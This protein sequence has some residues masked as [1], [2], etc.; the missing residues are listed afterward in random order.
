[1][2][3]GALT[4]TITAGVQGRPFQATINGLS[5]GK[6]D[7]RSD[8]APGFGV[9]NGKVLNEAL[10]YP[11]STVVLREY[12][13]G[14]SP[15]FRDT[16]IEITAATR[17]EL[18]AQAAAAVPGYVSRR[19]VADRQ[20]NGDLIYTMKVTDALGAT[21]SYAVGQP[22]A[23]SITGT[24]TS[25]TVGDS[26]AFNPS[27]SGGT[28]PYTLSLFS[29]ALPAGRAIVGLSVTGTYTTAATYNYTLRVTDNLGATA[30]LA[31]GPVVVAAV[32]VLG[33]L[34][35]SGTITNG[36]ASSGTISG[37]TAG[38][39]IVSNVTGLTVN[40]D[41]RTYT[42]DG[43]GAAGTVSNGLVETL[44][45]ATGSPKSNSITVAA[46]GGASNL[47]TFGGDQLTFNNDPLTYGVAA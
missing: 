2:A 34:S 23:L 36:T 7:V 18:Q 44:A 21:T 14:A 5:T 37:A 17:A 9:V 47:L 46:A 19:V 33:T 38:S 8:G 26:T 29:G 12:E 42:W 28:A 43:T 20:P 30:D 11:V 3:L 15:S 31:V 32:P 45:G 41:A 27:I 40:S 10:P 25:A 22:A 39:T 35:L 4:L 16:R 1:M 24:L 6:V 13:P